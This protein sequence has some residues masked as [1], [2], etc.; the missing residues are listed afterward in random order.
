MTSS[1]EEPPFGLA[2]FKKFQTS[3]VQRLMPPAS[4]LTI[5]QALLWSSL[6]QSILPAQ[7]AFEDAAEVALVFDHW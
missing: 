2:A 1:C 7:I 3:V 6:V 5:Y 4:L